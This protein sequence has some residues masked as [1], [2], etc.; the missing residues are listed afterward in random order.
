MPGRRARPALVAREVVALDPLLEFAERANAEALSGG[1][2][3][4]AQA[5][6][7]L[8]RAVDGD[9]FLDLLRGD[10]FVRSSVVARLIVVALGDLSEMGDHRVARGYGMIAPTRAAISGEA[11][12]PRSTSAARPSSVAKSAMAH[13]AVCMDETGAVPIAAAGDVREPA[14]RGSDG[15]MATGY[16]CT[17]GDRAQSMILLVARASMVM[18]KRAVPTRP[19]R[20]GVR[21]VPRF[22]YGD[23]FDV[24]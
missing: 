21:I 14:G 23:F 4:D 24:S 15:V 6:V 3:F 5:V 17:L 20:I 12:R 22:F 10:V 11:G 8:H 7:T 2:L 1:R 16:L 18:F 19:P 13:N 9:V